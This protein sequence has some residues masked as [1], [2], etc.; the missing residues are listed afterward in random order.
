MAIV[1]KNKVSVS[2]SAITMPANFVSAGDLILLFVS[3]YNN[4]SSAPS[5]YTQVRNFSA[6]N[7]YTTYTALYYKI[8]TGSEN[9][10]TITTNSYPPY[11]TNTLISITGHD[12]ATPIA[13]SSE[14]FSYSS[15]MT[16]ATITPTKKYRLLINMAEMANSSTQPNFTV[17][18][19]F[20]SETGTT[21]ATQY[22]RSNVYSDATTYAAN[23]AYNSFSVSTSQSG[24]FVGIAVYIAEG[25][26]PPSVT[27]QTPKNYDAIGT[28]S[29]PTTVS[30]TYSDTESNSQYKYEISYRAA[31]STGSY[32]TVTSANGVT[33]TSHTFTSNTFTDGIEYEWRLRLDDNQGGG[34]SPYS[35]A[36]FTAGTGK[37]IYGP[38][39]TSSST[40][41]VATTKQFL[42]HTF[43]S[44]T[45]GWQNNNFFGTYTD[46]TFTN[47]VT[48]PKTGTRSLEITWPTN[49][50]NGQS[51]CITQQI[52]GFVIGRRYRVYAD[53]Y[54]PSGSPNVRLDCFL[55]SAGTGATTGPIMDKDTWVAAWAEFEAVNT[56]I[57]FG[58]VVEQ[59][60]TNTQKCFVDNFRIEALPIT[61]SGSYQVQVRTADAQDFGPWS[62]SANMTVN[63]LPSNTDINLTPLRVGGNINVTW[64][65]SDINNQAQT[66]YKI[67]YRKKS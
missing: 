8:A 67:R 51:R 23:Q 43:E 6:T 28:V 41:N 55:Q 21:D 29:Q 15:S 5:G 4:S 44:S 11:S 26:V 49:G 50:T 52:P 46:C 20:T 13:S 42:N 53:I 60:T 48:R 25:N 32:T 10:G 17:P 62:T 14:T 57:F 22:W 30:W 37:W 64:D 35:T 34:W 63:T 3:S 66:K 27:S 58:I 59:Q 19:Q 56:D 2:G 61:E 65:Y 16:Y 18:A 1:I 24:S 54:V 7:S 39:V 45:E 47:S 38:P 40:S 9:G 36:Y 33:S 12:P 31:D